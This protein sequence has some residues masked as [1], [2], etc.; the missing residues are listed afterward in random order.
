MFA[1]FSIL[2]GLVLFVTSIMLISALRKVGIYI[3]KSIGFNCF[4][5]WQEY[6]KRM[7]P[8]I[9]TFAV[10]LVF[11][12][13][14]YV[15]FSIVNDLYFGY[16]FAMCIM[17]TFFVV[18]GAYGWILVYSLY[19]E[20]TDLTRLEDLAHLRV[21]IENFGYLMPYILMIEQL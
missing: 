9:Y 12:F 17:W 14:A 19:R 3:L 16:N 10:F 2:L 11:R 4:F 7:V 5:Q 1:S 6:E 8:W 15:F 20:L 18:V 21:S 13:L